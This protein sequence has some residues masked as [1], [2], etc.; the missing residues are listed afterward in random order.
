ME[1]P[2]DII[3]IIED[4][5]GLNDVPPPIFIDDEVVME[6]T[7]KK[8]TNAKYW[9]GTWNNYPPE[10]K[11]YFR[12]NEENL[13]YYVLA[14][15]IGKKG[16]P[17]IQFFIAFKEQTRFTKF[18]KMFPVVKKPWVYVKR[19]TCLQ[20]SNYCKKGLGPWEKGGLKEKHPLF[21]TGCEGKIFEWGVLPKEQWAGGAKTTEETWARNM[22]LAK[23]GLFDE[24]TPSHQILHH[25]K[26]VAYVERT[27]EELKDLDWIRGESPNIWYHGPTGTGKTYTARR[28][29]PPFYLKQKS[30]WWDRYTHDGFNS[31]I[32]EDLGMQHSWMG[33]FLKEWADIYPFAAEFKTGSFKDIRPKLI[34][35][36]SNYLPEQLFPDPNVHEPIRD[37]F[38]FIEM[39]ER[40]HGV[41]P[42]NQV[43]QLPPV[44]PPPNY[45]MFEVVREMFAVNRAN[46]IPVAPTVIDL[47]E[48]DD[49]S[50]ELVQFSF[51]DD[52]EEIKS[53]SD[54]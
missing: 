50:E 29:A 12:A 14:E 41:R 2:E 28:Y 17:H 23:Q 38:Q 37:R 39:R 53:E 42:G 30:K 1:I 11:T 18:M 36:T 19:G 32:I 24:M 44:V 7:T 26:Y 33:D 48:Y 52:D 13:Q 25:S 49:D 9:V 5:L 15:E 3:N 27:R 47:T 45:P 21:N 22:E 16:T 20:A 8:D 6:A 43:V 51:S 10:Y 4:D 34:I 31:V 40:Y 54:L 46:E 35:V